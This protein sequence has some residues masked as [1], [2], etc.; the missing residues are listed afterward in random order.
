MKNFKIL[1]EKLKR[2]ELLK[3][4]FWKTGLQKFFRYQI[5]TNPIR[6]FKYIYFKNKIINNLKHDKKYLKNKFN[7]LRNKKSDIFLH[8][9]TLYEYAKESNSVFETGVRGVVSSWA[10]LNGLYDSENKRPILFLNDI[11]ECDIF[12]LQQV[13]NNL[14]IDLKWSWEDNLS[15]EATSNFDIVFIDTLHVYG[16]LI[17]ELDKFS[18]ICDKYIILHDTTVDGADGEILRRNLDI[19]NFSQ[20]LNMPKNELSKG[21]WPAV[22][23]F[24]HT[25]KNWVLHKKFEFNNG[26]TILKKIY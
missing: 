24:L 20:M 19:N 6:F 9:D 13:S 3:F 22:E 18:K 4:L 10:F 21:L 17:R 2:R 14:S 7:L 5:F 1:I 8:L 12:D 16:Q 11:E 26:L 25:N 23:E 15:L